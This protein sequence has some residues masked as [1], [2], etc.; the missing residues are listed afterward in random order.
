MVT[1]SAYNAGQR[2]GVLDIDNDGNVRQFREK[3]P[4]ATPA[5]SISVI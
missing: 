3:N 4:K 5:P 2:F 1:V